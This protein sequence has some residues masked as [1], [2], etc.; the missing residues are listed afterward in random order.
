MDN[1][2]E[3]IKPELLMLV[4]VLYFL[5]LAIKGSPIKNWRIP[6]ILGAV[7]ILLS[8]IYIF[9][10]SGGGE[11]GEIMQIIFTAVTQ[12][13]LISGASVYLHNLIKQGKEGKSLNQTKVDFDTFTE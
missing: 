9:T 12:G 3:Y 8:L 2:A 1:I 11:F 6:Y 10:K 4:P 5:G 7:G 13:I